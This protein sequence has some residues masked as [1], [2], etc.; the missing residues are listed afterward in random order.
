MYFVHYGKS[1]NAEWEKE[2]LN[3]YFR[4]N[5]YNYVF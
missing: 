1:N 5:G 2:D 3:Y 4:N